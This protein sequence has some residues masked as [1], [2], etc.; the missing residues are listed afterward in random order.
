MR[1]RLCRTLPSPFNMWP[2]P[3]LMTIGLL[4]LCAAPAIAAAGSIEGSVTDTSGVAIAG[5]DVAFRSTAHR[6]EVS[7]DARGAFAIQSVDEGVYGLQVHATGFA[8]IAN[9]Q[10]AVSAGVATRVV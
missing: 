10:V 3:V 7:T 1:R 2:R 4:A 9:R 5:A 6:Y 8:P